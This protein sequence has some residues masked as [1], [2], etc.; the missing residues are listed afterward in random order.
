M[1]TTLHT[2]L[3]VYFAVISLF[4]VALTVYDKIA[5]KK[6]LRRISEKSLMITAALGG[7]VA[8]YFT[9]LLIRHK[10]RKTKFMAGIPAIATA[11][12]ALILFLHCRFFV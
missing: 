7:S 10:V 2:A 9:M 3:G 4:A 11:E 5:A 8:M 6:G 12:A 1:N